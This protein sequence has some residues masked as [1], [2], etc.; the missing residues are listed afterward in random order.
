MKL[1]FKSFKKV[2]D[3]PE[4]AV[5]KHADGH[6]I[7]LHKKNLSPENAKSLQALQMSTPDRQAYADGGPV[8]AES[9][10][11]SSRRDAL[12]H[13]FSSPRGALASVAGDAA[14]MLGLSNPTPP[15]VAPAAPDAAP[16]S[17]D[18][19]ADTQAPPPGP[20]PAAVSDPYGTEVFAKTLKSGMGNQ[21][22]GEQALA[23][24]QGDLGASEAP[25]FQSQADSLKTLNDSFN[26]HHNE[27]MQERQALLKDY[28]AGHIDPDHYLHNK[29]TFSKVSTGIGLLLGGLGAP[30]TGGHNQ[31]LDFLNSSIDRD[32]DAQKSNLGKQKSLLEANY[33]S[34]GDM[35]QATDM[36][37]IMMN[38][39]TAANIQAAAAKAADP[40]AKAR[41]QQAIGKIQ[42]DNADKMR[43]ISMMRA[44]SS[45][46]NIDP[47]FKIR[48]LVPKAQQ[49]GALKALDTQ[50]KLMAVRDQALGT[51]DDLDKA[52]LAGALHPHQRDLAK[53]AVAGALVKLNGARYNDANAA[54]LVD[55]LFPEKLD[56]QATR[57]YARQRLRQEIDGN[58]ES[59]ILDSYGIKVPMGKYDEHGFHQNSVEHKALEMIKKNPTGQREQQAAQILKR[60]IG[61]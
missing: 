18:P 50:K 26:Q 28:A 44:A 5:L 51:F 9:N 29:D 23:K 19:A 38:D 42:S 1:D 10:A 39:M 32:I 22:A 52:S 24:A 13:F 4:K 41:A 8:D 20:G 60:K 33:Q 21:I 45:T 49:E 47:A 27:L 59:S 16:A 14:P 25:I 37:K 11:E 2:H 12:S 56:S 31:A 36:T 57:D 3:S 35:R 17:I 58:A 15:E 43:E 53:A 61:G 40:M 48:A 55:K 7:H 6:E 30:A 46:A 34:M 54:S